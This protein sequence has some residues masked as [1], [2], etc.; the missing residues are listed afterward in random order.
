MKL[1]HV[2][3]IAVICLAGCALPPATAD[4]SPPSGVCLYAGQP[5]SIGAWLGDSMRCSG[6]T[7]I[8]V[9]NE[10]QPPPPTWQY[11]RWPGPGRPPTAVNAPPRASKS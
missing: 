8:A 9:G 7:A 2:I 6:D 1:S 11:E 4:N 10:K 3:W 5:Y